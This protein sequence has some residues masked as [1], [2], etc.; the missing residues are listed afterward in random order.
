MAAW[1][2]QRRTLSR[3]LA[4]WKLDLALRDHDDARLAPV[5]HAQGQPV[6]VVGDIRLL[7]PAPLSVPALERPVYVAVLREVL[8]GQW[9]IAPF[10]R[11]SLPATPGEWRTGLRAAPLRVLSL[12]NL[13]VVSTPTLSGAWRTRGMSEA[14]LKTARE[15]CDRATRPEETSAR[16][17]SDVG[18][19][20]LHPLDPRVI[21]LAE[22]RLL[23]DELLHAAPM[24]SAST[25]LT[26]ALPE[27][28]RTMLLAAEPPAKNDPWRTP[29]RDSPQSG[30]RAKHK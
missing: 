28:D 27:P 10:S 21:Y 26:Y 3:W 16:P 2:R 1:R 15:R 22:E 17:A 11:F 23:L 4:E 13:R 8:A 18:P 9:E 20:L 24:H 14:R 19:P 12:W 29:P 25:T 5:C 30:N 7:P 6:P